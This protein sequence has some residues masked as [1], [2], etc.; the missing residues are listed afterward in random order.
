MQ[1]MVVDDEEGVRRSIKKVLQKDGYEVILAER[2][3]E[4]IRLVESNGHELETVISDYKMPGLNGLETLYAIGKINPQVTRI[5]LTGYATLDSAI[6]A[7]NRGIDG[8][9]TKPFDNDE[10]R[11]K[12]KEC[13]L[14]KRLSQFV[15]EPVFRVLVSENTPVT[16]SVKYASVMFVDI[17]NFSQMAEEIKT[18][19]LPSFLDRNYF[20]PL[21]DLI[22]AYNGTLDK[23]MGDGIMAVFGAPVTTGQDALNAVRCAKKMQEQISQINEQIG[24][25]RLKFGIGIG[26]ST[27]EVTAGIFG[28]RKKKEYTVFGP[29]VNLAAHLQEAAGRGEIMI[30]HE[31]FQQVKEYIEAEKMS[32]PLM[33]KR[34]RTVE[35]YRIKGWHGD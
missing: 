18:Q 32:L 26:I 33:K 1:I 5:I 29:P 11:I 3:E 21:D 25:E 6:E 15:S 34:E 30:C 20:S 35:G 13:N 28:S 19:A 10:L 31:T 23:H 9:L 22:H 16:A 4:A 12:V 24:N 14:R 2:G 8:F 17:R 7:I 27:G